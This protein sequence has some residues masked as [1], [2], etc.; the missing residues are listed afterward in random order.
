MT[1]S[2]ADA[3][4]FHLRGLE[5]Q[6]EGSAHRLGEEVIWLGR[7]AE[8]TSA[9]P[10]HLLFHDQSVS[11]GHAV[12]VWAEAYGSYVLHHR[13]QTNPTFLNQQPMSEPQLLKTG[14]VVSVGRQI[15]CFEP[16]SLESDTPVP[17]PVSEEESVVETA[18]PL[19]LDEQDEVSADAGESQEKRIQIELPGEPVVAK[20]TE[21]LSEEDVPVELKLVRKPVSNDSLSLNVGFR[22]QESTIFAAARDTITL[23]FDP[24]F[25]SVEGPYSEDDDKNVVF[26]LPGRLK[27]ELCFQHQDS[28][29]KTYLKTDAG[30]HAT[31]KRLTTVSGIILDFPVQAKERVLVSQ[32]DIVLHQDIECWLADDNEGQS[33]IELDL[34]LDDSESSFKSESLGALRFQN[35]AWNGATISFVSDS[36]NS[37]KVGPGSFI[38]AHRMP[39]QNAPN[40]RIDFEN[41]RANILVEEAQDGQYLSLNGELLFHDQSARLLSG[42]GLFLGTLILHWIQP[43]LHAE[44]SRYTMVV[45]NMVFPINKSLVRIGTAAHCE[46]LLSGTGLAEITGT[47]EYTH[48]GFIYTHLEDSYPALIEGKSV[49]KG[50]EATVEDGASLQLGLG[51]IL[52]L[53]AK[54]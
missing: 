21:E 29:E 12:L 47:L 52:E 39:I 40:C 26:H 41:N 28:E 50:E 22:V 31:T 53:K 30:A 51:N 19:E 18:P 44:L 15:L 3:N 2:Q 36:K 5:G 35:G 23:R 10:H 49:L 34:G 13:S 27:A 46:I 37:L 45:E 24:D 7:V 4:S 25:A 20:I 9:E 48:G 17:S 1:A 54:P 6:Y 8:G 42:S 16:I 33:S 14:D 32:E 38:G 43:K 11:R